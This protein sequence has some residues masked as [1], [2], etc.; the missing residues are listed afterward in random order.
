MK[1]KAKKNKIISFSTAVCIVSGGIDSICTAAYLK[2]QN[3]DLYII[4]FSY[5]QRA[6]LEIEKA[7]LISITLMT[8]HGLI[9]L[10]SASG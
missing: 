2:K 6:N 7:Q 9:T 10:P 1:F 8:L 4:T 3:F 5:G